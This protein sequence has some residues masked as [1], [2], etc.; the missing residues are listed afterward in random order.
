[1]NKTFHMGRLTHD[2]EVS[3]TQGTNM[4]IAKFSLAVPRAF[5]KEGQPDVDFF[6]IVSFGKTAEFV[7]K[8][9]TK[10]QQVL[11]CGRLQNRD[12][13]DKDGKKVYV[14]EIIADEVHFADS[15]KDNK[16]SKESF[17]NGFKPKPVK[18][19]GFAVVEAKEELPF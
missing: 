3:F 16:N 14:T 2:P 9:F 15:K 8:Y 13:D 12:Y 10:G 19:A 11:V 18:D 1:M 5:K 17:E 6:N 4:C 7:S